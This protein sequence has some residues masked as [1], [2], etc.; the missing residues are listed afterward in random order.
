MTYVEKFK[1]LKM[2]KSIS[3]RNPEK[4]STAKPLG[5]PPLEYK[6]I[7]IEPDINFYDIEEG[8]NT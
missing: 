6:S 8:D 2:A 5:K 4:S 3:K 7:G 1:N